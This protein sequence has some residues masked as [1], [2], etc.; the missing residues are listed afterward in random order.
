MQI[1]PLIPREKKPLQ[2]N[3]FYNAT[4][5]PFVIKE[6]WKRWP[7][8]N[9]GFRTKGII[10]VDV[11]CHK[12]GEDGR[13]T[14]WDWQKEYGTLP[15]TWI[16][17]TPTGGEHYYFRSENPLLTKAEGVGPG[18]D[19]RGPS[20]YVLLPPSIHPD[21]GTRYEWDA[22]H[23]PN[24]TPLSDLPEW[25]LEKLL[26]AT[27]NENQNTPHE[28]PEK[29]PHGSRNKELFYYAC[30]L[31][32]KGLTAQE[33]LPSMLELNKRCDPALKES[34]V[35]QICES[36]CRYARGERNK[37]K[38]QAPVKTTYNA[39]PA[40]EFG[41]QVIDF[42]WYPYIVKREV[43]TWMAS[44]GTGKTIALCLVAAYVSKGLAFPG[45]Y[46]PPHPAN[47]LFISSED[48][49]ELLR[50]RLIKCNADLRRIYILDCVD[51]IGLNFGE[52]PQEFQE[53]LAQ[54]NPALVVVDPLTAFLGDVNM[55][56][57]NCVR[58]VMQQLSAIAK[59][60][61]CAIILVSH[62]NKKS[63]E[64]NLN[65]SASG[66]SDF[67]DA[68]RSAVFLAFDESDDNSRLIVHSKYNYTAPGK[69]IRFTFDHN[70]GIFW[71][72]YSEVD[73][74]TIEEANR[75]HKTAA[76]V[77]RTKNENIALSETL[78]RAIQDAAENNNTAKFSYEAFKER[79]G[80]EIFGNQMPKRALDSLIEPMKNR[81]ILLETGKRIRTGESVENGFFVSLIPQDT[82]QMIE[83]CE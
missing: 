65:N 7:N 29:I 71:N 38:E 45:D 36:A 14:L 43:N 63:Q 24:E 39:K 79:Y 13:E 31:R 17:K 80:S 64:S 52:R 2:E 25:L 20:G 30:S 51:S 40:S 44:G 78:I 6:Y 3:G 19:Y 27:A 23:M 33:M 4:D 46:K 50:D 75:R 34:E 42:I 67:V 77:L 21:T 72:G 32:G 48:T 81:G 8:A 54:Y 68:A 82:Q 1:F 53:V 73:R 57:R 15:D 5:D 28:I 66:S 16:C 55:D 22:G 12:D 10:V 58:P 41:K 26:K 60:V 76:E 70:G 74:F 69:T 83:G 35:K 61:D 56:R 47:V 49:G 62:V 59:A 9:I 11:D 37:P 18:I